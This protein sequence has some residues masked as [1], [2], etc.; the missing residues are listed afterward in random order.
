ML[1]GPRVW[2][3]ARRH[4]DL[5]LSIVH[6]RF[7][8]LLYVKPDLLGLYIQLCKPTTHMLLDVED[9]KPVKPS[10]W[11]KGGAN[12]VSSQISRGNNRPVEGAAEYAAPCEVSWRQVREH[13]RQRISV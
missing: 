10:V 2:N 1:C 6:K 7:R 4:P 13:Y 12:E 9:P 3:G 8:V 5:V 11:G